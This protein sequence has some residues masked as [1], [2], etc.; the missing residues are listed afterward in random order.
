[1]EQI[2]QGLAI[3]YPEYISVSFTLDLDNINLKNNITSNDV[4]KLF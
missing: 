1:M 3:N 4:L 2:L